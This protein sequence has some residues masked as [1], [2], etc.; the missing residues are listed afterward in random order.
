MQLSQKRK[1]FSEFFFAFSKFKLN[2][3]YFLKKDEP[4]SSCIFELTESERR[5]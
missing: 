1:I 5:G 4:H 3:E 2:F